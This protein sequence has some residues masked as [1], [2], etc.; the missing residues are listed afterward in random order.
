[1]I[2]LTGPAGCGKDTVATRLYRGYNYERYS[3]AQPL[4]DALNVMLDLDPLD[5]STHLKEQKLDWLGVSP[6]QLAQTLGTEWGR[7]IIHPDIWL[8][9]AGRRLERMNAKKVVIIDC[10]FE[11][12]AAWVRARGGQLWHI[13]G[14][15]KDGVNPHV[16]E[17]GVAL[18][19]GDIEVDNS[20]EVFALYEQIDRLVAA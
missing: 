10:R 12:E 7:D 5:W 14:R 15:R 9:I 17:S 1:M 19:D 6:R 18:A 20:G 4:K 8:K 16:S 13:R 11:N 2:A 3:F